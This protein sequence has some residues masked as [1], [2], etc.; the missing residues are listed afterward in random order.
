MIV[1]HLHVPRTGGSSLRKALRAGAHADRFIAYESVEQVEQDPKLPQENVIVSGHFRW[2]LHKRFNRDHLYLIVLRDPVERVASHYD[3]V[4][5]HERHKENALWSG[6][7]LDKFLAEPSCPAELSNWQTRQVAGTG[8]KPMSPARMEEAWLNLSQDNVI[9][10]FTDMLNDGLLQLG[11]HTGV[12]FD[13][14]RRAH[15]AS[16]RSLLREETVAL[17]RARNLLDIELYERA[18]A[19]FATRL[20]NP[21]RLPHASPHELYDE[22]VARIREIEERAD[23]IARLQEANRRLRA[24]LAAQWPRKILR[25]VK[26]LAP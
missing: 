13:Y 12:R 1:F 3:F 22:R 15:N 10:T 24:K 4:R 7:P 21:A 18:R 20:E 26:K 6:T 19:A 8:S 2:G 17:I 16:A 25:E 5:G 11:A 9:V 23:E 14:I